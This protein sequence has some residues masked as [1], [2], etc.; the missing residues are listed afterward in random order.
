MRID[1]RS[2]AAAC[3]WIGCATAILTGPPVPLLITGEPGAGKTWLV[4]RLVAGLSA[5]WRPAFVELTSALDGLEL[6]RLVGDELGLA[7]PDRLGAARLMLADGLRDADA[8]G[9]SWLLVVDEA[10]R[11]GDEAGEEIQ[12]LA[13]QLGQAGGFAALI[14]LGRTELA[15]ELA[16]RRPRDWSS[17]LGLHIH[18]PPMDLD[19][20]REFLGPRRMPGRAGAGG[21]PPRC[22]GQSPGDA[23]DRRGPGVGLPSGRGGVRTRPACR[24]AAAPA[25]PS[26]RRG[27]PATSAR[28]AGRGRADRDR[29]PRRRCGPAATPLVDPRPA[30]DPARGRAGRGRLGGRPGGGAHASGAAADRGRGRAAARGRASGEQLVEDRYAALQAWAE[31]SRNRERSATS[32]I[33]PS[34]AA[35]AFASDEIARRPGDRPRTVPARR[36]AGGCGL[37]ADSS[38]RAETPHDF[39]P[40]SQLFTRLR[41]SL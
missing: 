18:L 28:E 36:S 19:E 27:R 37:R 11:A 4:R 29:R 15:R 31:W 30:P 3:A 7:M 22:P 32:A 10:Q 20:A 13:N 39:A 40:Y 23:P 26:A 21:A 6:L 35:D 16:A 25:R 1:A 14:L 41:H 17:R 9:R 34:A 5:G 33:E 38:V 8:D 12:V 2:T 24:R